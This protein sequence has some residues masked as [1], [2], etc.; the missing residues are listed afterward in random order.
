MSKRIFK[1]KD[2]ERFVIAMV[3]RL[4]VFHPECAPNNSEARWIT[5]QK[6]CCACCGEPIW[7]E[8]NQNDNHQK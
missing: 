4:Q 2:G 5:T 8:V 1:K 3:H 6:T 7:K